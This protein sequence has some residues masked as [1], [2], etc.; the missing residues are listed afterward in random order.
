MKLCPKCG[1]H[2]SDDRN[3][4]IDCGTMLGKPL[5]EAEERAVNEEISDTLHGM[6]ERTQEFYVS[7]AER[8]IGILCIV[9]SVMM[10]ILLNVY[11]VQKTALEEQLP[12]NF[13][14]SIDGGSIDGE[15][16]IITGDGTGILSD[17]YASDALDNMEHMDRAM[18]YCLIAL[19]CLIFSALLFLVPKVMWF[20]DTLR[21]RLWFDGNPSPSDYYLITTK[22]LKYAVFAVGVL[23]AAG[24]MTYLTV[25]L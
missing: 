15:R 7:P 20:L 8:V 25:I 10:V 17:A 11:S 13:I 3:N 23:C 21:Y 12:E 2:Q 9:L 18:T 14:G 16:I 1:A 5:T 24:A 4:C 19:V 22:I 6:S